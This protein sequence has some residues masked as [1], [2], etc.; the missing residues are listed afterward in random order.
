M[1]YPSVLVVGSGARGSL[2]TAYLRA[3]LKAGVRRAD[4]FDLE[5]YRSFVSGPGL[6]RR[7]WNAA[8]TPISARRIE[9][10]LLRFL[11]EHQGEYGVV[12]LFKGMEISRE[13]LES[14]RRVRPSTIWVNVNPDDPLNI[15]SRSSSN[16][17]VLESL[18]FF[19][20]YFI[21]S[22]TLI[23]KLHDRGCRRVEYLPFGYDP[24]SHVPP[25]EP[26][27]EFGGT[28]SFVGAWDPQRE[29]LL[30]AFAD[31]DLRIFGNSWDRVSRNSPLR[32]KILPRNVYG[33]KLTEIMNGSAVCLN[34]LRPQNYGAH[35]MRTFE[36]P[37]MGGLMLTTRSEEQERYFPEGEGCLMFGGVKELREKLDLLLGDRPT[38][39]K[40]RRRGMEL[41]MGNSYTERAQTLLEMVRS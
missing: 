20:I 24:D 11:S 39:E 6:M 36:I 13:L 18:S 17:N 32:H 5:S 26:S 41:V 1:A 21:W 7:G 29:E 34:L 14:C 19:D 31:Y 22:R 40:I 16:A 9:R 2:E 30:S 4:L 38:A 10:S 12:V 27:A 37:A 15:E 33:R 8:M 25:A 23:S 28:I 35:N 3:F